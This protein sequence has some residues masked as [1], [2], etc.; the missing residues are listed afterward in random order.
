MSIDFQTAQWKLH[1]SNNYIIH[2]RQKTKKEGQNSRHHIGTQDLRTNISNNRDWI[3]YDL[4]KEI[5]SSKLKIFKFSKDFTKRCPN[6]SSVITDQS[7][8]N[9]MHM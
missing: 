2:S 3:W 5:V 9:T 6:N 7:L 4:L 8:I 1:N